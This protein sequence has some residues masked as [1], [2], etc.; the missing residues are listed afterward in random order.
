MNRTKSDL[1]DPTQLFGDFMNLTSQAQAASVDVMMNN[2]EGGLDFF[3]SLL[4]RAEEMTARGN[5]MLMRMVD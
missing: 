1:F 4:K 2:W 3:A 5:V